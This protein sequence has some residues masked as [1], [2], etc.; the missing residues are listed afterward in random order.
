MGSLVFVKGLAWAET[1]GQTPV[2]D[3]A[4]GGFG[5]I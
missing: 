4:A 5:Q 3:S 2:S 1:K